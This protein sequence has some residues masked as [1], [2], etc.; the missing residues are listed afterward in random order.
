[1]N[2]SE[3][4]EETSE[5]GNDKPRSFELN[6]RRRRI[7]HRLRNV[8]R[9]RGVISEDVYCMRNVVLSESAFWCPNSVCVAFSVQINNHFNLA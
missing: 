9:E 4:V 7:G 6:G 1:M 8:F 2:V 3:T 5:D